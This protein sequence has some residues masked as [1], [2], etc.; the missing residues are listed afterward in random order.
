M[1]IGTIETVKP[2]LSTFSFVPIFGPNHQFQEHRKSP[3]QYG[4]SEI[5]LS[6]NI[7]V[8]KR[9]EMQALEGN[10][11]SEGIFLTGKYYQ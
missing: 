4:T 5:D 10:V 9:R 11:G 6:W 1:I 8:H 2:S 7:V 3:C